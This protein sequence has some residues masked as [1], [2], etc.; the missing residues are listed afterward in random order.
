MISLPHTVIGATIA[1]KVASPAISLPLAF[2]SHFVFD[3]LI[4][5]WN[6]HIY[7]EVNHEGKVSARSK[8][9]IFIDVLSALAVGIAIALRFYPDLLRVATILA[10]CFLAVL[11]DLIEAPYFF[12]FHSRNKYLVSYIKLHRHFQKNNS[13]WPGILTQIVILAVCFFL[14]FA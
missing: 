5:H 11:P 4:P 6:P 10:A 12:F 7:R 13:F 8:K 9:I 2:I 14:I 3:N 1:V